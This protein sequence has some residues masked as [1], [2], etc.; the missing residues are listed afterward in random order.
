MVIFRV[1][2]EVITGGLWTHCLGN[3]EGLLCLFYIL[4]EMCGVVLCVTKFSDRFC[5]WPMIQHMV[6]MVYCE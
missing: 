5:S 1:L 4:W 2:G 3:G 6:L